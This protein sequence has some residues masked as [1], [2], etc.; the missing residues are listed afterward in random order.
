MALVAEWNDLPVGGGVAIVAILTADLRFML[1]PG[2]S[3]ICRRLAVAFGAII[4]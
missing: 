3:N 2:C 4:I 1:P